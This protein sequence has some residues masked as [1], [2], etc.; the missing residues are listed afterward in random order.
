MTRR[1][2]LLV[3]DDPRVLRCFASMLGGDEYDVET[4]DSGFGLTLVLRRYRPDVVLLDL[5]MPGLQGDAAIRAGAEVLGLDPAP[6]L[7]IVS[8]LGEDELRH[9]SQLIGANPSKGRP[10]SSR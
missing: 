7:I 2:I 1:R 8:G 10:A 9:R 4:H 5:N 3:D 6:K